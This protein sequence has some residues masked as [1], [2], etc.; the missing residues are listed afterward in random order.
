MT[1]DQ[2]FAG[3][4]VIGLVISTVNAMLISNADFKSD[5]EDRMGVPHGTPEWVVV[6]SLV[7]VLFFW[8]ITVLGGGYTL[9]KHFT[10]KSK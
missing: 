2:V 8:P 1:A 7:G 9:A 4:F 6:V 5:Y 10:R 3:Y